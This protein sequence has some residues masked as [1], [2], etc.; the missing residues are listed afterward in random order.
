[1]R[2]ATEGDAIVVA[3]YSTISAALRQNLKKQGEFKNEILKKRR[4]LNEE[5]EITMW[6]KII[7]I[8]TL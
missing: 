4:A 2:S 5:R 3:N 6:E 7:K 1:M 8:L